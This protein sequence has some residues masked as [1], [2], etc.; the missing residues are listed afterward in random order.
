MK[1]IL[2]GIIASATALSVHSTAT[3]VIIYPEHCPIVTYTDENTPSLFIETDDGVYMPGPVNEFTIDYT[4][5]DD[6][7]YIM[8]LHSIGRNSPLLHTVPVDDITT[9][10]L[11]YP[12]T[13]TITAIECGN[14]NW[15]NIY[16]T[17][18]GYFATRRIE[19]SNGEPE[20]D[21]IRY[22][23][24]NGYAAS[25]MFNPETG[26][27]LSLT[28][29]DINLI[30]NASP[31]I[32]YDIDGNGD[33][34]ESECEFA[35]DMELTVDVPSSTPRE[36]SLYSIPVVIIM[37]DAEVP[38]DHHL[39]SYTGHPTLSADNPLAPRLYAVARSLSDNFISGFD[40]PM[41]STL[42]SVFYDIAMIPSCQKCG[43]NPDLNIPVIG[44]AMG[45]P[46][47]PSG[48]TETTS[49]IVVMTQG[50]KNITDTKAVLTGAVRCH[51]P[52][53]RT[54]GS[55][56]IL[57]DT[58]ESR[59]IKGSAMYDLPGSQDKLKL[60]FDVNASGLE[61]NT[62]YYYRAY[63]KLNS[64]KSDLAIKFDNRDPDKI[65]DKTPTE[66]YGKTKRFTT[67]P[68]DI[69]GVWHFVNS[70]FADNLYFDLK[71]DP[72]SGKYKAYDFYGV[73]RLEVEVYRDRRVTLNFI[74]NQSG[75][76]FS[77]YFNDGYSSAKG[78]GTSTYMSDP[79]PFFMTR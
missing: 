54:E 1:T 50:A 10:Q 65:S 12:Y 40:Y 5:A 6:G 8:A 42:H 11:Y 67:A 13:G 4:M 3:A 41:L 9:M 30:F 48:D 64:A 59:L 58:D 27:P 7:S 35:C 19:H 52:R 74:G 36:T 20:Y 17:P 60:S 66:T 26:I 21:E 37:P 31:H 23:S 68:P 47:G 79:T 39:L 61:P 69:S 55:Y 70:V 51:S 49:D 71:F 72:H 15:D 45:G 24:F 32:V 53:F 16:A 57:V 25:M 22:L 43:E 38:Q 46:S 2:K 44:I 56:G 28:T 73:F 76:G 63:Y 18:R 78:T 77:G 75:A 34:I 14:E 62:D 29:P 33:P